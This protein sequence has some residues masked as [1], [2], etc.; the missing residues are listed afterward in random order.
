MISA[1]LTFHTLT[2]RQGGVALVAIAFGMLRGSWDVDAHGSQRGLSGRYTTR[3]VEALMEEVGFPPA[4]AAAFQLA[5]L[6][7]GDVLE[8]DEQDMTQDLGLSRLQVRPRR[9][10]GS[11]QMLRE[12]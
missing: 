10:Q 4:V 6:T 1:P 8:L 2:R 5:G 9:E 3:E 11:G 7:G 12:T